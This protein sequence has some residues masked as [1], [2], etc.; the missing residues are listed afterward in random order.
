MSRMNAEQRLLV[1]KKKWAG[2]TYA[3]LV[4][5][6][7]S[8]PVSYKVQDGQRTFWVK[9]YKLEHNEEYF[10]LAI[11]VV[12]NEM[13]GIVPVHDSILIYGDGRADA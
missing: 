1:E 2:K 9:V 7:R 8:G 12:D 11:D 3:D 5:A 13:S 4:N 6:C 10:H